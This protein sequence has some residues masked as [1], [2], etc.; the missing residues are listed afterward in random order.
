M[1]ITAEICPVKI[2]GAVQPAPEISAPGAVLMEPSTGT[3]L[4]EKN[5]EE[6]RSP[7]SITKIMTLL[8]I[9]EALEDGQ[10][11]LEEEVVT[12]AYAK[13]MGGSQVFLEEG[14]KQTVETL[15]KCIVVAS[16]NDAS[17]VMAE[18][19]AGSEE[20]F[21]KRMNEKAGEL[22]MLHT[23][24]EDCCGLTD[25]EEHY[26]TA[27]D[28]AIVSRELITR[29]PRILE[30]S[31][32]WMENI[33]H[34]TAQGE[35]EFCLTNTNKLIRSYEGCVVLKTG[36]TSV[37]KYCVSAVAQ[38]GEMTLLAVVMGAPDAKVRFKDAAALLDYGF[39]NCDLYL[40]ENRINPDPVPIKGGVKAEVA[41]RYTG[42]F[43]YLDTEGK[44]L[45]QI[46]KKIVYMKN[47]QAPV[48]K[49]DIVGEAQY[50]L[51]GKVVGK[52]DIVAAKSVKKAGLWDYI[53]HIRKRMIKGDDYS[54]DR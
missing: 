2:Q 24:F 21:V 16:G 12:S 50:L 18:H 28:V 1:L 49:G 35:K 10:I 11:T 19:L 42:E 14:E 5:G 34:R 32:I 40:D 6:Q 9:F 7:A 48:K 17:V 3:V 51:D 29:F 36:S 33:I 53:K 13:S 22:G 30:Y 26:T 47:L 23:Q 43:R 46:E 39:G 41:C 45:S 54:A 4:Y 20:E 38:R 25:S 44:N 52:T 15:I 27:S 37:A 31:S 8:L